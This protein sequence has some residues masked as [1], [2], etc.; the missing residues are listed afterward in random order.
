L[1]RCLKV[2]SC[3]C[4]CGC[5]E[6]KKYT[7]AKIYNPSG[8][9]SLSY[10]IGTHARFKADMLLSIPSKPTLKELKTR[11]ESDLSIGLMDSWALVADVLTFYQERISNEGFLRTAT[12]RRS[13]LELARSIGYELKPGV[14][15]SA[16]LTFS[17]DTAAGSP[18]KAAIGIGT[19]VQS[20]PAQ[21][22]L[23]QVFETVEE[24][25]VQQAWNEIKP[26][27]TEKQNLQAA[28]AN[29]EVVL[30]GTS[31]KLKAGD[32]LL[33]A[34]GGTKAAFVIAKQVVVDAESQQT[35]ILFSKTTP[36]DSPPIE[37]EEDLVETDFTIDSESL[38]G[39]SEIR[40]MIGSSWTEQDLQ[41]KATIEGWSMDD[42]V[43]AI[44]SEREGEE[45]GDTVYAFRVKCGVFGSLAPKWDS[46]PPEQKYDHT[47]DTTYTINRTNTKT[48]PAIYGA[49]WD[50]GSGIPVNKNSSNTDF[51]GD[52]GYLVYLDN[53]Y[54]NIQ[55]DSWIILANSSKVS[56]FLVTKASEASVTG[57]AITA[58]AT[59][60]TFSSDAINGWIKFSTNATSILDDLSGFYF[61]TTTVYA[62]PEK[63]ELANAAV[64]TAIEGKEILL[65][66]MVGGLRQK[67][68]ITV[69]GELEEQPGIIR[70]EIA[71]LSSIVHF[72]DGKL[73]TKLYLLEPLGYKYKRN[74]VKINANV[75]KSTHG[76]TKEVAIGGG[77]PTQ[78]FQEFVLKHSPLTYVPG[79]TVSGAKSTLQVAVDGIRWEEKESFED[80]SNYDRAFVTRMS[81]DGKTTVIFGD[82]RT[83]R[84][85]PAGQENVKAK[86]RVGIG[87]EGL[88][89]ADQLSLLMTRPLG[90]RGV[91]NPL[92]TSGAEDPESLYNARKNAPR[93]VLTMDRVVSLEDYKNFA[94]GF[95]GVGK[96]TS[97]GVRIAGNYVVLV[98][99]S[100]EKGEELDTD[101]RNRLVE[102]IESYK[103]P[104]A[105]FTV[106]S[107]QPRAFNIEAKIMVSNRK[108]FE[109][110]KAVVENALKDSFSFD[111][112]DF[113]QAVTVSEVMSVIQGVEGVEAVDIEYLYE[114]KEGAG[115]EVNKREEI[116]RAAGTEDDEGVIIPSLLLINED[117]I[118]LE[119]MQA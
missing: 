70:K 112:R 71:I 61:R 24:I 19:K 48:V 3:D 72:E 46:L 12:E 14:A 109:D 102:A 45:S 8:Q 108:E 10:R 7:P 73:L 52:S 100:A 84:L 15:A 79:G 50:A 57:F 103:D 18:K 83:G 29:G 65:D 51:Y 36:I 54:Q 92:K 82:G 62:A 31:T 6:A 69:A 39:Q 59:G 28:L 63:L 20:V 40:K 80:R 110:V 11:E 88:L 115:P 64:E 66:S 27:Q 117:K 87:S 75:A 9:P 49:N 95:A 43:E 26:Q 96:A 38:L 78:R 90:V 86:Y 74:T 91:T 56:G 35:R 97:Y 98:A 85:P 118:K 22:Q 47:S 37:N 30:A 105:Q 99:V 33:F 94:Q 119:N 101:L 89:K 60:L 113:G 16:C 116:I 5:Q 1:W 17:M 58:K 34:I 41:S 111:S 93:T 55:P 76:E 21:G 114:H 81:D 106:R 25:E 4:N 53:T 107:F 32:G 77:D 68:P 67:R 2:D 42:I 104:A 13:V 44:N 23:P